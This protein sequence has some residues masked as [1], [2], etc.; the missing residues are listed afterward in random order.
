MSRLA[1]RRRGHTGRVRI[2]RTLV[3]RVVGT[4]AGLAAGA[5]T[6]ALMRKSWQRAKG[7]DPPTNPAAANVTWPDA[8]AWTL[9]SAVA[10]GLARLIA[11]RGAAEAWRAA[12]GAYPDV[13]E[14]SA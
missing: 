11:Q 10:L 9:A 3:W 5:A 12:T 13:D 7:S 8:L 4:L 14:V 6:R 2:E 1:A